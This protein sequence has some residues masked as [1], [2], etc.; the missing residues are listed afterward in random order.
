MLDTSA[1]PTTAADRTVAPTAAGTP[2]PAPL[3][4]RPRT[5]VLGR[6]EVPWDFPVVT[7]DDAGLGR[8]DGC[9]E[10]LRVLGG[11]RGPR[12]LQLEAHLARF[13]RSAAALDLPVPDPGLWLALVQPLLAEVGEGQEATLRM[14]L[15][16]GTPTG[17]PT[18]VVTLREVPEVTRRAR[19]DGISVVTLDRGVVPDAYT[20]APWLLGGTKTLSYVLNMAALREAARRGADDVLFRTGDGEVLEG[21]TSTLVWS[22]DGEL[23]TTP[24]DRGGILAGTTL[25]AAFDGARAAGRRTAVR[26]TDVG[27]LGRADGVWFLSS[28]RGAVEVTSIDAHRLFRDPATTRDLR[29]WIEA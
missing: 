22:A 2:A 19:E 27:E 14:L 5:A 24:T 29:S 1:T 4:V 12:L 20:S 6:G 7:A 17:G 3:P 16:R 26:R 18:G 11:P 9:F 25:Q 23:L 8:G 28:V 21:P 15:T 10:T 13:A